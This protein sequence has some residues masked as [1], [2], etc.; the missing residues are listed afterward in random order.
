[1]TYFRIQPIGA[2]LLGW[3]SEASEGLLDDGLV[4]AWPVTGRAND[5]VLPMEWRH[6]GAEVEVVIFEGEEEEDPGDWEGVAVRPLR[7]LERVSCVEWL[8]RGFDMEDLDEATEAAIERQI[9]L[10]EEE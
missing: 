7:V 9:E 3:T 10:L 2:E 8:A 6:Y 4:F 1:M 5:A